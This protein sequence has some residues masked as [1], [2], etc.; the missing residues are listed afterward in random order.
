M[1]DEGRLLLIQNFLLTMM[2]IAVIGPDQGLPLVSLS[3]VIRI[4]ILSSEI[5]AHL[6]K[7]W[8]TMLRA[9]H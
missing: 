8:E 9:E 3:H 1:N 5:R 4:A 7:A 6:A 2:E